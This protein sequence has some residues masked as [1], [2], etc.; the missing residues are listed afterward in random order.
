MEKYISVTKETMA[1][2]RKTFKIGGKP[3]CERT[4]KNALTYRNHSDLAKRIRKMALQNYGVTYIV[5]KE[6]ECFYTADKDM[7]MLFPN[8]AEFRASMITGEGVLYF[9]N[10]VV[11]RWPE[12]KMSMIEKIKG[13]AAAL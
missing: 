6:M 2:L 3:V 1:K 7:V 4:I 9:K 8:G 12:I 13:Q 5:A 11:E 10:Q